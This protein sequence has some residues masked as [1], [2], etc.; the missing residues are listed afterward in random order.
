VDTEI[1]AQKIRQYSPLACLMYLIS[2]KEVT[3]TK[4]NAAPPVPVTSM[5]NILKTQMET[6]V[7]IVYL[8]VLLNSL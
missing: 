6:A 7:C 3:H 8:A 4:K 1:K 2:G 5:T